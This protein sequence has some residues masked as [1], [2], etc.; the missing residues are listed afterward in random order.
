MNE[1]SRLIGRKP[2]DTLVRQRLQK[3][4]QSP[5][6]SPGAGRS[7]TWLRGRPSVELHAHPF[8]KI[9]GSNRMRTVPDG[10][11][12][13]FGTDPDEPYV[14]ILCIEACSSLQNLLDKRS[15]FAPSTTSLIA[16]CPLP[17]LLA[18]FQADD[19][20]PRWRVIGLLRAE[21][22]IP[23]NVPVRDVRVLYGLKPRQYDGFARSQAPQGHEYFCPMEVLTA[24]RGHENPDLR[25]LLS[26]ASL[27]AAFMNPP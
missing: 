1:F 9:P 15:R 27:Y 5:P 25:S 22:S 6:G 17:W 8:L 26:R 12:L 24:E 21:P 20:T 10:L 7:G 16:S 19:P 23:L 2:L 3:W 11:W 13:N 14:D 4:P 18:P